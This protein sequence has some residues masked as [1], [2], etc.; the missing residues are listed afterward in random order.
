MEARAEGNDADR[1][2]LIIASPW[3]V[4]SQ[5]AVSLRTQSGHAAFSSCHF[6]FKVVAQK[7]LILEA[8]L[9]KLPFLLI[10]AGPVPH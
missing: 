5:W 9:S 3:L 7:D 2:S 10:W 8:F 6:V 4:M 1:S